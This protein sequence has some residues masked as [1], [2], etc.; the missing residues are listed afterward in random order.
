MEQESARSLL[1]H[2]SGHGPM[3]ITV[4]PTE[5]RAA[6]IITFI[7][8]HFRD[9]TGLADLTIDLDSAKGEEHDVH[10]CTY[11]DRGLVP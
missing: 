1:F 10:L 3:D 8:V 9:M 5:G 6:Y 2:R 7:R 4:R 11:P